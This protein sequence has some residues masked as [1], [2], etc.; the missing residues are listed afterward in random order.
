MNTLLDTILFLSQ[1]GKSGF[2]TQ[3]GAL[4]GAKSAHRNLPARLSLC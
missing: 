1:E 2:V 4:R 3:D